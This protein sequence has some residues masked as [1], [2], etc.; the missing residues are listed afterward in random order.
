MAE[1]VAERM[2]LERAYKVMQRLRRRLGGQVDAFG[3]PEKYCRLYLNIYARAY[4]RHYALSYE[5]A[6]TEFFD[7]AL[8]RLRA[9]ES[10]QTAPEVPTEEAR[11]A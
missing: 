3:F 4:V 5:D 9:Q 1:E 10:F 6:F 8:E 2:A 7:E 11:L